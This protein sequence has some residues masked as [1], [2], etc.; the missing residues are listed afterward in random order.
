MA[1]GDEKAISL[2][3]ESTEEDVDTVEDKKLL[4]K[5]DLRHVCTVLFLLPYFCSEWK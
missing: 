2:R 5:V 1:I 3:S 4:R